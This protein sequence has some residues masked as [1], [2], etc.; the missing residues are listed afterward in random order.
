MTKLAL[1]QRHGLSAREFQTI[2]EL[3]GREPN[4]LELGLFSLNWSEHCSYKSSK[5]FLKL[6]PT[7]GKRVLQGPGENA[8]VLELENNWCVVF[9]VESHNHPSAVEPFNGA[10]TGVGGIIRDI[11]SMG[12]RPIALL[13]SLRFGDLSP[14]PFPK[15]KG[16]SP[17]S[18]GEGLGERSQRL[19]EGVVAGIAHYGN[20]IG[21]PTVGGDICFEEAYTDNCLVN[22]MCV[23]LLKK[24]ELK[25]AVAQGVGNRILLVGARTGRD[26]IHGATFASEDLLG[27][28]EE[29]RPNVQVGDPFTGKLLIEA[30]LEACQLSELI[31]LQDLGAG[32]LST[33]PPEMA[34]R[35]EVGMAI[36]IEE[37]PLRAEKM[38][39]YEIL[40]SESQERMVLCVKDGSEQKF[41]KIYRKWGLEAD[42]IGEVIRERV[43][44]IR[45][46][47]RTIAE[48][49]VRALVEGVPEPRAEAPG[50]ED[51]S[52]LKGA[53]GA[54]LSTLLPAQPVTS[55]TGWREALKKLLH[56]PTIGSKRW[57]YEQYDHTVQ[58]NTVIGP[59][60]HDA[61]L[62]RVKGERFALAVTMGGNG[63]YCFLDPYEGGIRAVCEAVHNLLSVGAEPIGIT[64][65]LNFAN[66]TDPEVLW[67]LDQ[68]VRGMAQAAQ[69]F[70]LPFVSGNVSLYNQS[71]RRKIYPTPIVGMIGLLTDIVH[72]VP[73]GFQREGDLLYLIGKLSGKSGGSEYL[74]VFYNVIGGELEPTDLELERR[75]L[76]VMLLL[77]GANGRSPLLRSAHDISEGGLLVAL[78]EKGFARG[79]GAKLELDDLSEEEGL[80]GEWPSR[81]IV[82]IPPENKSAFQE[83]LN[84]L[85]VPYRFLGTVSGR[86]LELNGQEISV[87]ELR[88]A[89][90]S[91]LNL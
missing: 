43:Y 26:G 16:S 33:A 6:L 23:G 5:R 12:A 1:A 31:G 79:L 85:D 27:E 38:T 24:S 83:I 70:E 14:F 67:S 45:H 53:E 56:S 74:K 61:A 78:A 75:L 41:L 90:E 54:C 29:K 36:D 76:R 49:P 63:R 28:T 9:K 66:P 47:G 21:I 65:C 25:R 77:G 55:V 88:N 42:V 20:C 48:V 59:G 10:A 81:F 57:V 17:P 35:G 91:A 22:T 72:R 51:L 87:E 58:T 84:S 46:E 52:P 34:A 32:G 8:G 13:D 39:P 40:L 19:L 68:T 80:F 69:A 2:C 62:L 73:M 86:Q 50:S 60:A 7:T 11:L 64:D 30:T 89:Y 18:L 3:L 15:G 4:E 82:T 71:E 44:R 37:I